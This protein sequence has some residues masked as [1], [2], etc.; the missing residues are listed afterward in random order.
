[1]AQLGSEHALSEAEILRITCAKGGSSV[2]ADACLVRGT[3]NTQE[4]WFAFQ[5]GVLL[6]IGD[7]LQDVGEDL[8]RGSQTVFTRAI[9][10]GRP[11]DS[12]VHQLLNFSDM[13]AAC[14]DE[15]PH[16]ETFF[17]DLLRMSWRSLIF[18]AVGR[19]CTFFTPAFVE[20][21][22]AHSAFRFAFLRAR[23][24]KLARDNELIQRLFR[25]ASAEDAELSAR[26]PQPVRQYRIYSPLQSSA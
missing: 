22:E 7:D 24:K 20:Q 11:L 17:K 21:I 2:L 13:V 23:Q 1:M 6:Q 15:L 8:E 16:G 18:G 3:L 5:W 25:A 9:H 26:L 19:A 10:E 14:M 12:L 4:A